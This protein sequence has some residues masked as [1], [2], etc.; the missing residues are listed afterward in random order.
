MSPN[1]LDE[2]DPSMWVAKTKVAPA[3]IHKV[4]LVLSSGQLFSELYQGK[5]VTEVY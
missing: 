2:N 5:I 3:K 4:I 1:K